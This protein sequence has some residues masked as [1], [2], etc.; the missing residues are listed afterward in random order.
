MRI[1]CEA[2]LSSDRRHSHSRTLS[3]LVGKFANAESADGPDVGLKHFKVSPAGVEFLVG[4]AGPELFVPRQAGVI[5]PNNRL[6]SAAAAGAAAAVMGAA[7]RGVTFGDINVQ[8][9]A[10]PVGIADAIAWRMK[11]AGI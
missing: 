2:Y 9:Q 3:R 8:S 7:S 5:I 1:V 11:T 10:D 6:D 4:E